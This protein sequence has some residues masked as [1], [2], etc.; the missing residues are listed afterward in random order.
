MNREH[1]EGLSEKGQWDIKVALRG[2][3]SYFGETLKWFT[4]AVIR[5]QV[6]EIFRVGGSVNSDLKLVILPKGYT[7]DNSGP[8][9]ATRFSWN[10]SHFIEHI[11]QAATWL[12]IP[13]LKIPR[14]LW[15]QTMQR[16]SYVQ[17]A[18]EILAYLQSKQA[19]DEEEEAT[20]PSPFG[21][22]YRRGQSAQIKELERHYMEVLGGKYKVAYPH[23]TG[24]Q[25]V[26]P[27]SI[28]GESDATNTI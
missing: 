2:P 6:R 3:D 14:D 8:E 28:E 26:P 17:A 20:S 7:Y 22:S 25:V 15:N 18:K 4:T 11:S 13:V 21:S 27:T 23:P 24:A 1:W 16:S 19:K 10:A 12:G 5:G 9:Q